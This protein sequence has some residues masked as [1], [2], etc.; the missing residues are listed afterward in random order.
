MWALMCSAAPGRHTAEMLRE[1]DGLVERRGDFDAERQRT[2]AE[3]LANYQAADDDADRYNI[4]RSLY[5]SYRSYRI[6]S[7]IIIAEKRL[8]V[9]RRM[10]AP[11]KVASAT[12]NLAEGYLKSGSS[13]KA[14]AL[15]DTLSATGLKEYHRKYRNSIYRSAYEMRASSALLGRDRVESM[16]MARKYRDEAAANGDVSARGKYVYEAERLRDAGMTDQAVAMMEEADRQFDFSSDAAMLYTMGDMYLAAGR[17]DEAIEKLTKSAIID[18]SSGTKEYHSLI[19]LAS[20]LFEDGQVERAFDYINCAFED[21]TFSKASI[22]TSEIMK[23]MS[24]IDKAFHDSESREAARTKRFL[25]FAAVF[26]VMLLALLAVAIYF[27]Q[28]KRRMV[29]ITKEV[30]SRLE[31]QNAALVEA[32]SLKLS[33]INSLML[34]NATYI[35]R[36]KDFRK[37]VMRL[38]KTSQWEKAYDTVKSDRLEARDIATFHEMFDNAFLSMYPDFVDRINSVMSEP[39]VLKSDGQLTP[40][41][42]LAAMIKLGMKS[43]DEI[44]RMLHYSAQTVYNLR[45][46][47][48]LKLAVGWDEFEEFLSGKRG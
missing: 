7:A 13:E 3:A 5:E 42:R 23:S 26:V 2:I 32:D 20:I 34:A 25:I 39:I 19:L 47:L 31:S 37:T 4:L 33:H 12:L 15:L 40:E 1:L 9:A 21:A 29:A 41:L 35:S 22:R 30:N 27:Y 28:G 38:M 45:S 43:T 46:S 10:G 44:A 16:E 17:R 36:L 6:D 8:E 48:R 11:E 18:L 24:V 14:I